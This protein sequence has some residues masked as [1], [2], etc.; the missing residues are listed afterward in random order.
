MVSGCGTYLNGGGNIQA[1]LHAWD[2][3]LQ[4]PQVLALNSDG[5]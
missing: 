1:L 3:Q 4:N 2:V 5:S